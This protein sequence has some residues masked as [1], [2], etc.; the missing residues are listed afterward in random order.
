MRGD[1]QI[2]ESLN[3]VLTNELTAVNQYF[4]HS[5]MQ[6]NWGYKY[7]SE[8]Y[9]HESIDE[10]KHADR[11]IHRVLYLGGL[12]N[13]QRLHTL[14]IGETVPEQLELDRTHETNAVDTLREAIVLSRT[15]NDIGSAVL[16]EEILTSEEEH[17]DWLDSQLELISQ[18]G[19]PEYL[20]QQIRED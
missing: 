13:L 19:A 20:S 14:R 5:R 3:A 2:V 6:R 7:I 4:L 1:E 8:H 16:L 18:L 12:P 9:Y 15:K 11:I 10:M 17:I